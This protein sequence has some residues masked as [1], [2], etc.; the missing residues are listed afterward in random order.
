MPPAS[1]VATPSAA[2][3]SVVGIYPDTV[4]PLIEPPVTDMLLLF[5]VAIDPKPVTSVLGTVALAVI[6]AVPL[7]FT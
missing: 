7:P 6:A 5:W 3:F 1:S 2:A 4:V